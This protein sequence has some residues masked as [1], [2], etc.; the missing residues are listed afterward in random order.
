M[1]VWRL[2]L[3]LGIGPKSATVPIYAAECSPAPIRGAL[4]MVNPTVPVLKRPLKLIILLVLANIY[5]CWNCVGTAGQY[6][7]V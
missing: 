4:V 2:V 3:G 1:L 7:P 6:G 5:R